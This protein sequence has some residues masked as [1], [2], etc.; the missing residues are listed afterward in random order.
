MAAII[1]S[2]IVV[3]VAGKLISYIIFGITHDPTD[4]E[5]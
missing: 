4:E 1:F 5:G 2:I 3:G